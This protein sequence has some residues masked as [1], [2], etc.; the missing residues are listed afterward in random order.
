M[1]AKQIAI[2][3]LCA[4]LNMLDGY[5]LLVIGFV[6]P[7]LP[8]E[9]ATAAEKGLLIS[10]ALVGMGIG[11]IVLARIADRLGRRWTVIAGLVVNVV[12]LVGSALA[13]NFEALLAARFVTGLALGT[14]SVV[15]VVIAQEATPEARHSTATGIVMLGFPLGSTIAGFGGSWALAVSGGAWQSLFWV[16]AVLTGVGL[17]VAVVGMP[18]SAAFREGRRRV[19]PSEA[20]AGDEVA[21]DPAPH[22]LGPELRARTLLLSVGYGML[23]AA[24]YFVGTWTPQLITDATQDASAGA[25]VG[26]LFSV[27]TLVGAVGFALLGLR[28]SAAPMTACLLAVAVLSLVGFAVLLPSAASYV[29]AGLLGV[30]VFASACG[31]TS[32]IPVAY[33]VLARAKGYGTMLGVGRVGATVAPAIVGFALAVMTPIAL[34]LTAVVP[35]AIAAAATLGLIAMSRSRAGRAVRPS[36][37]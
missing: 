13:P 3:A 19:A 15:I 24:Y 18:E 30:G 27:G 33:P 17:L 12:G 31:Y 23:S 35:L 9:L 14:I 1:S 26:I 36:D 34:Y 2:V 16:G 8:S 5:D 22:L 25:T 28:F 11:A 37:N 4:F 20:G 7:H 29:L 21:G 6:L 10:S 32:I